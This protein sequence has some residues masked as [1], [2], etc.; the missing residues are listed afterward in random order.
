LSGKRV[1]VCSS[2][3]ILGAS[4][5]RLLADEMD[6]D[7]I[8]ITNTDENGL[9]EAIR[10]AEPN[11][12]IFSSPKINENLALPLKIIANNPELTLITI[13]SDDNW[14]RAYSKKEILLSQASDL[15][16][17]IRSQ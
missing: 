7:V 16:E 10:N 8:G 4:L 17:I 15:A 6:M 13:N 2:E 11:I 9:M 12:V 14:V 1:L 3:L 5:M